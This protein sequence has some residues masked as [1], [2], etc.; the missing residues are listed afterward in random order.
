MTKIKLFC[1]PYGGGSAAVYYDW[2]QYL[3]ENIEL[4]AVELAARGRRIHEPNYN[5]VDDAVDANELFTILMGERVEP[6]REFIKN[7][8]S[9]V[10]NLDI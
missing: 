6:R 2:K 10:E 8:A 9:D 5:S 4:Y 3:N 7:H 1:F